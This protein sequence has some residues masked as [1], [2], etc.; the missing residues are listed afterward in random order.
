MLDEGV[1]V[2]TIIGIIFGVAVFLIC[3][4]LLYRWGNKSK[5]QQADQGSSDY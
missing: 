4:I 1:S 2:G 5:T 3:S